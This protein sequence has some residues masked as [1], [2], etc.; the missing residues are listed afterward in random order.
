MKRLG[1]FILVQLEG[2]TQN[3]IRPEWKPGWDVGIE[4]T[5]P[6]RSILSLN[7]ACLI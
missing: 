4:E 3:L 5:H 6:L 7:Q 2:Y 1:G